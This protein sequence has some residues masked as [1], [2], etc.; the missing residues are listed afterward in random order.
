LA[1]ILLLAVWIGPVSFAQTDAW[2]LLKWA[3]APA[4]ASAESQVIPAGQAL[5]LAPGTM[6]RLTLADGSVVGG[7]FLGRT[8][9]DSTLYAPRFASYART[10][11]FVPFAL[12]ETLSVSLRDGREWRAPFAGYGEMTVLLENPDGKGVWR[13]P[14]EF[15]KEFRGARGAW[16]Q[17]K[18]LARAFHNSSLPSAEALAIGDRGATPGTPEAW[19]AALR[20]AVQDIKS[21]TIDLPSGAPGTPSGGG[22]SVAGAVVV[23]AVVAVVLFY[24]ILG[25]NARS[26][27]STNCESMALP[28]TMGGT[29]VRLTTQPFDRSRSCY[30]DDPVAVAEVW[31]GEPVAPHA[32][33]TP[34]PLLATS[35][36]P[37]SAAPLAIPAEA[38]P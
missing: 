2:Q 5:V 24:V 4:T 8:L 9:L 11:D 35:A 26:T 21:A 18:A 13:V 37:R 7:R 23:G 20:V 38:N 36:A 16:V 1:A 33:T 28:N 17:P 10:S 22:G 32:G 25:A 15:A 19:E 31:P 30:A 3:G 27:S 34:E 29:S 12:G 14:F 6:L